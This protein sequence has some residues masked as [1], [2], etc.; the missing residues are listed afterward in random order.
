MSYTRLIRGD[1]L[2]ELYRIADKSID[3]IFAD[4][5]YGTTQCKWDSTL[6]LVILWGHYKRVLKDDGIIALFAQTPFDKVLGA[7]N[8]EMLRYEWIWEK[9]NAT[10]HLNSK[11]MPMKAHEN[12]LVFYKDKPSKAKNFKRTYNFQKTKGHKPANFRTKKVDVQNRTQVYGKTNKEDTSGGYTDRFPRSVLKF[13]SDKQISKLHS[14]QKPLALNEYF[15]KTYTNEGDTV[16]D[17]TMGS[18]R[19]GVAC[20][21]LNRSYIGIELEQEIFNDAG[22]D[23]LNYG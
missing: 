21:K 18:G 10:G 14:T 22:T 20:R 23:I 7:S 19:S 11:I 6:D 15:I 12:I 5:P 2:Q 4:L 1:C 17:N 13:K 3:F 9:T 8:L 16:L